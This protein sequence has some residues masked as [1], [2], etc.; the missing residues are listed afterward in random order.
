MFAILECRSTRGSLRECGVGL[1]SFLG[2]A[3][4][5]AALGFPNSADEIRVFNLG[6][7]A[8]AYGAIAQNWPVLCAHDRLESICQVQ[9]MR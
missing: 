2:D 8:R 9:V 7:L 1:C 5:S 6:D 4:F 3:R